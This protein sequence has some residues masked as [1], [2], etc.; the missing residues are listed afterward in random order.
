MSLTKPTTTTNRR[1]TT[2]MRTPVV[3]STKTSRRGFGYADYK[4][5]YDECQLALN[6]YNALA[7]DI[8]GPS[9]GP[10]N[11]TLHNIAPFDSGQGDGEA[12]PYYALPGAKGTVVARRNQAQEDSGEMRWRK[13][14]SGDGN[15]GAGD[16]ERDEKRSTDYGNTGTD[17]EGAGGGDSTFK[18]PLGF[19]SYS[20]SSVSGGVEGKTNNG[21]GTVG[22][23]FKYGSVGVGADTSTTT[24]SAELKMKSFSIAWQ[25][26]L[27]PIQS[28]MANLGKTDTSESD[29]KDDKVLYPNATKAFEYWFGT[30]DSPDPA[31]DY[32]DIALI[33]Y[34]PIFAMEF[35]D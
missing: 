33:I 11:A 2:P 12:V 26:A 14:G 24:T 34:H 8:F 19:F 35:A 1:E 31:T 13:T 6:K 21:C 28:L 32:N 25:A 10:I 3:G 27:L 4:M 15:T 17:A 9:R 30:H 23:Q 22:L 5:T 7:D 16:G 18:V 29:D 20:S